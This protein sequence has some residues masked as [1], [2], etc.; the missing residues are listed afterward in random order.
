MTIPNASPKLY[1]YRPRNARI[2]A[3]E[4]R[5]CNNA[6]EEHAGYPHGLLRRFG[7]SSCRP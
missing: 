7:G 6:R 4:N 2:N 5:P 1:A 3:E